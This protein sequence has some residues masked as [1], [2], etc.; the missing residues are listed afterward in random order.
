MSESSESKP[1]YHE[2][3]HER[4][5]REVGV[6]RTLRDWASF[7]ADHWYRRALEGLGGLDRRKVELELEPRQRKLVR[8]PVATTDE[9]STLW[10]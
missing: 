10:P 8:S 2:I 4:L 6:E 5:S 3:S 7:R 9:G 1:T